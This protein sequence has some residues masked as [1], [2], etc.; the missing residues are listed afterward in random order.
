MI[1]AR[2][3]RIAS[4]PDHGTFGALTIDGQP[5]C[6]TLEPYHND[7]ERNISCIPTGQYICKPY[8][9][10][11]Y[12]NTYEVTGVANRSHILFHAGNWDDDTNGCILLGESF[13]TIGND[14]TIS[15]SRDALTD[16]LSMVHS[17]FQL[18]ITESY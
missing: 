16:F 17:T 3:T 14:F 2:L 7:N 10:E 9:S 11:R 4:H 18:T 8:S 5:I 1:Q 15:N 12:P 6:V 13:S